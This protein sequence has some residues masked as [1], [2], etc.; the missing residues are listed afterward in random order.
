MDMRL[1]NLINE[2]LIE[3]ELK[4]S[5]KEDVILEMVTLLEKAGKVS[6]R[7]IYFKSVIER[8]NL[9][10][11]GIGKGIA[12]PHGK[13]DVINEVSIAFGRSTRGIDFDSLDDKPVNLVFLL[14]A[15]KN[16]GGVYLKA[17]AQLSRLLRQQEFRES[18]LSANNKSEVLDILAKA[19]QA[20]Q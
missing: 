7:E 2:E 9:G 12:I 18:I 19:D 15:P 10:S 5:K 6:D 8:E 20:D 16:V 11:T 13:S 4:A 1:T 17:L 14:A 3:L